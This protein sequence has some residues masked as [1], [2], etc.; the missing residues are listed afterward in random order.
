MKNEGYDLEHASRTIGDAAI[1]QGSLK[2]VTI[3]V[4]GTIWMNR[5][6]HATS[7]GK[8]REKGGDNLG[9]LWAHRRARE[10]VHRGQ[11]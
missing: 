10:I 8:K 9:S 4:S 3:R 2:A 5:S 7:A 6:L 11:S 1:V